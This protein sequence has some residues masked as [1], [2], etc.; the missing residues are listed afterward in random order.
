[1]SI[2]PLREQ[3]RS[4]PSTGTAPMVAVTSGT[5]GCMASEA[6]PIDLQA[7]L[8]G[9]ELLQWFHSLCLYSDL[10]TKLTNLSMVRALKLGIESSPVFCSH[11]PFFPLQLGRVEL[12]EAG[13]V[14][15]HKI[16][17]LFT[18]VGSRKE[19]SSARTHPWVYY[20]YHIK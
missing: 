2:A 11:M 20:Q 15:K 9:Q 4:T 1:V 8:Q 10:L 14:I 7:V 5:N 13:A 16:P 3:C 6:R 12:K 17:C 18:R 19:I